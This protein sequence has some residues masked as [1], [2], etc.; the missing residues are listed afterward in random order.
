MLK[1][2]DRPRPLSPTLRDRKR[3]IAFQVISEQKVLGSDVF[4][5]I[6]HA[7]LNFLGERGVAEAN[8]WLSKPNYDDVKQI[9]II[10]CSHMSVEQVR[11]ALALVQRIG[12]TRSIINVL[13][14]SGTIRAAK[15][16][17][18][19]ETNLQAFG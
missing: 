9:G 17:F 7:L 8:V 3:Y 14:V 10:K 15:A 4:S 19:G 5:S 18:F 11:T 12:D 1:L 2:D 6:W 13:G 16:K